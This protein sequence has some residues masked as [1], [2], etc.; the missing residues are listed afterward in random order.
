MLDVLIANILAME[1]FVDV[2]IHAKDIPFPQRELLHICLNLNTARGHKCIAS[3][4]YARPRP[5]CNFNGFF[6]LILF[7]LFITRGKDFFH[8]TRRGFPLRFDILVGGEVGGDERMLGVLSNKEYMTYGAYTGVF[9][10]V[11]TVSYF[12]CICSP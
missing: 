11:I 8:N 10:L 3:I 5:R 6:F 7:F 2:H 4:F 1:L 9:F 12:P